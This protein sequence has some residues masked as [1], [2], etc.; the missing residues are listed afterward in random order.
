MLTTELHRAWWFIVTV[1]LW[2]IVMALLVGCASPSAPPTCEDAVSKAAAIAE[3]FTLQPNNT[4]GR[5]WSALLTVRYPHGTAQIG[6]VGRTPQE[7]AAH[8]LRLVVPK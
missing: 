8:A 6:G 2:S 1:I 5:E 3:H 7:A 4:P